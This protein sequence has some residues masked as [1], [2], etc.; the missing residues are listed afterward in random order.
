M[1]QRWTQ[2][3]KVT[4]SVSKR[5][6]IKDKAKGASKVEHPAFLPYAKMFSV[7]DADFPKTF[8]IYL[9]NTVKTLIL[10]CFLN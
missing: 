4:V 9:P 10:S 2:A 3:I 6:D 5:A 8:R 7:N 1:I